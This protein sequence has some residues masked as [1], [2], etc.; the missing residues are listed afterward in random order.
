MPTPRVSVMAQSRAA[1]FL[2]A[3]WIGGYEA[4]V[5]FNGTGP[6]ATANFPI[7]IDGLT[8]SEAAAGDNRT[9]FLRLHRV[10]VL[11][12]TAAVADAY[13]VAVRTRNVLSGPAPLQDVEEALSAPVD[14]T[15]AGLTTIS[16]DDLAL[17]N[18]F[19]DAALTEP[20]RW[21]GTP[22]EGERDA[23]FGSF[24]EAAFT[25]TNLTSA[26]A[27]SVVATYERRGYLS[28]DPDDD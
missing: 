16:G 27:L 14:L 10:D 23:R 28:G 12:W 9:A 6:A 2:P 7:R 18:H 5:L 25:V 1:R 15:S 4:I 22:P 17:R 8:P 24:I 19:R 13:T 26:P 3:P 20:T 21:A 11:V